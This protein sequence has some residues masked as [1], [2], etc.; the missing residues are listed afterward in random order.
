[1]VLYINDIKITIK[2]EG[3]TVKQSKY[4]C[5]FSTAENIDLNIVKGKVLLLFPKADQTRVF[6]D[7]LESVK[8]KI[9]DVKI[10]THSPKEFAETVFNDHKTILA[11][12]G[13]VSNENGE[14]LMIYRNK[15]WDFPKGKL[16]KGEEI[17]ECAEREVEEECMV[18]VS[19]GNKICKTRHTYKGSKDDV[20]KVTYWYEMELKDD[21]NMAPQKN[22]GIEKVEW[23]TPEEAIEL[24]NDSFKSLTWLLEKY[25][26]LKGTNSLISLPNL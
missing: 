7:E 10:I 16:D 4:N 3:S 15:K 26:K 5:I 6:F 23:K 12:G 21:S 1:M 18:K 20:M 13:I 25:H 17:I 19:V 8:N 9:R 22:E 2:K 24:L 11:G 14:L